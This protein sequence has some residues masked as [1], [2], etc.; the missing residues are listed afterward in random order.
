VEKRLHWGSYRAIV[1]S[2]VAAL[3]N[4]VYSYDKMV[5]NWPSDIRLFRIFIRK[6]KTPGLNAPALSQKETGRECAR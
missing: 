5:W 3:S 4:E 6:T 1:E 2:Q